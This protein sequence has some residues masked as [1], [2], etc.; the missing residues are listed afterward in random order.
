[1]ATH[2]RILAWRIPMGRGTWRATVHGG[3]RESD[4][5]V[6]KHGE[7]QAGTAGPAASPG[8]THGALSP[9]S[10]HSDTKPEK[11]RSFAG[12][13]GCSQASAPPL[14][15]PPT[16]PPPSAPRT[17]SCPLPPPHFSVGNQIPRS[18]QER[19]VKGGLTFTPSCLE[20]G[21]DLMRTFFLCSA[22][23]GGPAAPKGICRSGDSHPIRASS[24]GS[25]SKANLKKKK[26]KAGLPWWSSG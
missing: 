8:F 6:T 16:P 2:S 22:L 19:K 24:H 7:T 17:Q 5:T 26:K 23:P 10:G 12:L 20:C 3:R 18:I 14:P 1:M 25:F 4:T 9:S 21:R 15:T 11:P 13:Q